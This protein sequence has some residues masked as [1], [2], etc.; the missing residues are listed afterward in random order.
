MSTEIYARFAQ[1]SPA[2]LHRFTKAVDRL[3]TDYKTELSPWCTSAS[4]RAFDLACVGPSLILI[5]PLLGMIAIVIRLTSVGPVVFR[6]QRAGQHGNVFTIYKF[7]TMIENSEA[8]GPEHTAKG[9]PRLTPFGKFLRRFKLDELPQL[10]NVLRGDM[11]LVGPR[12]KLPNHDCIHTACLPGVT[13]PATLAFRREEDILR[14]VQP[15]HLSEFYQKY[16]LPCKVQLDAAY[17]NKATLAK[18]VGLLFA[19]ILHVGKS[20]TYQDL[21]SSAYWPSN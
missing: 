7:R 1:G 5:S 17:L 11:S 18:D 6:Q 3:Q 14:E 19:T 20:L 4:K 8:I 21:L 2:T 10:Y 16:V 13:G 9:D 12:P 15:E